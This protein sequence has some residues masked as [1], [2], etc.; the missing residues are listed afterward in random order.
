MTKYNVL[1]VK[2]RRILAGNE[3]LTAIGSGS[4]ICHAQLACFGML[5]D[6]ILVG[7]F[8]AVNRFTSRA[9]SVCKVSSLN[10]KILDHA[11]ESRPL[12]VQGLSRR[13]RSLFS[14]TQAPEIFCGFWCNILVHLHDNA[15]QIF[16][17][18]LNLKE[19]MWIVTIRIRHQNA[20]FVIVHVDLSEHAPKCRLFLLFRVCRR[21]LE[22][23]QGFSHLLVRFVNSIG[24]HQIHL[25]LLVQT[26][27]NPRQTTSVQ[28]LDV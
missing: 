7:K 15:S 6:K 11:V 21:L 16:L 27:M 5:D 1:I 25:G 18:L 4:S 12:E 26:E 13:P 10:H 22:Q 9:I 28:R 23:R 20:L 24:V 2:M 19:H 17:A 8:L 3:K 14:G